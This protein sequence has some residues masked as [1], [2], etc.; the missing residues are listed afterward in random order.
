MT[1]DE[2]AGRARRCALL[3][4]LVALSLPVHRSRG[5]T[6]ALHDSERGLIAKCWAGGDS[7][8][9]LAELRRCGLIEGRG[10]LRAAAR[11]K[12]DIYSNER[13]VWRAD[14]DESRLIAAR[15]LWGGAAWEAR[16]SPVARYLAG[17]GVTIPPPPSLRWAP[18]C[19]HRIASATRIE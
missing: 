2:I 8:D 12:C 11:G 1:A 15:R 19:S 9:V 14:D 4:W 18:R 16:G 13:T 7:R 5:A 3:G 10:E 6:L 17:R